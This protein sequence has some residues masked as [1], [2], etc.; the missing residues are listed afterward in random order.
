[1]KGLVFASLIMGIIGVAVGINVTN[2]EEGFIELD[3]SAAAIIG[4]VAIILNF[5]GAIVT[6]L[7][8][9]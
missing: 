1:A 8:R 3:L 6:L 2:D 4:I 7:I 5:I 9:S